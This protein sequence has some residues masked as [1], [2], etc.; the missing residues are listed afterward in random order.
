MP[1]PVPVERLAKKLDQ[2]RR[3][4]AK[5]PVGGAF[6]L[7]EL[8]QDGAVDE[9][10]T[11]VDTHAPQ[12]RAERV[13]D[14]ERSV[15]DVVVEVDEARHVD[16][17]FRRALR[18]QVP[19][20]VRRAV[21]VLVELESRHSGVAA[22]DRDERV[23]HGSQSGRAPPFTLLVGG[24]S[25][26]APNVCRIS[27]SG[28]RFVDL[29]ARAE[30]DHGLSVRSRHDLASIRRHAGP[31]SERA[32]VESLE[33]RELRVLALDVHDRLVRLCGLT[34]VER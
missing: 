5:L 12:T 26:R 11:R 3:H 20:R 16:V 1:V 27:R 13:G 31:I 19:N 17:A 7:L 30:H 28:L 21:D 15:H 22:V 29:V 18:R 6:L 25:R 24:D 32:K 34:V 8:A 9:R 2:S 14:A 33:M 4:P 10:L 23:G